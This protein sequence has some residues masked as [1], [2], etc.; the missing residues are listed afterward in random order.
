MEKLLKKLDDLDVA[1]KEQKEE[2][3]K[4]VLDEAEKEQKGDY[5]I[6]K[7][8]LIKAL[9]KAGQREAALKLRNWGEKDEEA[10]KMEK[11]ME[12]GSLADAITS[13]IQGSGS[14]PQEGMNTAIGNIFG[15][16]SS[17]PPPPPPPPSGD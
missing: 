2:L 13:G 5:K 1:L 7:S 8:D 10:V 15:G 12:K 6:K 16:S 4:G 3:E 9:E 14:T 17:N 11:E